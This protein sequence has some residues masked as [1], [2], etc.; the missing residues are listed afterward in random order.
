MPP[1]PIGPASMLNVSALI[2]QTGSFPP[3][4]CA[5]TQAIRF[6]ESR[7]TPVGHSPSGI[8]VMTGTL[9]LFQT[10]ALPEY[11][12]ASHQMLFPEFTSAPSPPA[13]PTATWAKVAPSTSSGCWP[14]PER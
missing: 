10:L 2:A 5:V 3:P 12:S 13:A 11:R 9:L 7:Q 8:G 1:L 14:W 6:T 4:H